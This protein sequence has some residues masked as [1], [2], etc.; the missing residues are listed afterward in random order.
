MLA[1]IC[2]AL[3]CIGAGGPGGGGGELDARDFP[4][5]ADAGV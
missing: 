2:I 1:T 3:L 5:D 4:G